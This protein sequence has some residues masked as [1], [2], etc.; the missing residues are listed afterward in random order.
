VWCGVRNGKQTL[1]RGVYAQERGFW[2]RKKEGMGE[3][4]LQ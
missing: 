4:N 2:R 3:Q 1:W